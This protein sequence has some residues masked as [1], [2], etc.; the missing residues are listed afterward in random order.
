M[1]GVLNWGYYPA[2]NKWV[3][4]RVD[5]DGS[6]HVVGYVDKL[7]DIGDVS[8][9][10]PA[11]GD[12]FY[13]DDATG[14]WKSRKLADAD[15]PATI[16]RDAEADTKVSDHA[17]LPAAHHP[18]TVATG[19]NYVGDDTVNRAIP[20]GLAAAPK[21]VMITRGSGDTFFRIHY[22]YA[23]IFYQKAVTSQSGYLDVT[24]PDNTNFYVGNATDYSRSANA[25]GLYYTWVAIG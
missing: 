20:H 15:I 19:A 24:L 16:C 4:L 14:L 10:A 7:D 9:A 21:I 23:R 1:P 5:E 6:I 8:V 2:E 11:D 25:A 3:P 13:Y 17:A 18:R 12:F 22:I